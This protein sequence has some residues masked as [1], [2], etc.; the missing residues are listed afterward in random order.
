M[1]PLHGSM[2]QYMGWKIDF[3][4]PRGEPAYAEPGSVSWRVFANPVAL[5]I[6][7]VCAVLLEFAD[8]RIRSGVWDH[9]TFPT[10]PI[11][12]GQRTGMA[13]Q[14]GVFGPRSAAED[15]IARITRMHAKVEGEAP[16]GTPY[17]ALDAELLNW[18]AAT[19]S[20]GFV[21]AYHRFVRAL[22]AEEADRFFVEAI[23]V[24]RLYGAADLPASLAEFERMCDARIA[25]FEPHPINLEFLAI[26]GS[27]KAV[28]GVPDWLK[29]ELAN[30]A[31][32]ILPP[33]VRRVLELGDAYDL[34]RSG[35]LAIRALGRLADV[36]PRP[37]SPPGH[38][39]E[40]LGLPRSFP[41][42][43]R[44]RQAKLLLA[45]E[46]GRNGLSSGSIQKYT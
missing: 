38:A 18:V 32:A 39:S 13:A 41:W 21:M 46:K 1:D 14:I 19:A 35:R 17:R 30:A 4:R 42:L 20:Y 23:P 10:D 8:R 6:G 34:S 7:G 28:P 16:D 15:V 5:A 31:I 2:K 44:T 12:R 43:S 29:R 11:G 33:A 27:T 45:R 40:R 37:D 25:G 3:T 24:G 26:V 9:S 22:G 36:V